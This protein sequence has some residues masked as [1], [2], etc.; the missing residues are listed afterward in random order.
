MQYC[1]VPETSPGL[2]ERKRQLTQRAI[3]RAVLTLAAERGFAQVTIEEVS[4][5]ADIAP[6]TFFNYFATKEAALLGNVPLEP[7]AA[8]A[9]RFVAGGPHGELFVDFGELMV[10]QF[11]GSLIDRELLQLRHAVF[12]ESPHLAKLHFATMRNLEERFA[13][14]IRARIAEH[15]PAVEA[16]AVLLSN[17]ASATMRSAFMSWSRADDGSSL[18]EWIRRS[19]SSVCRVVDEYR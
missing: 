14:L 7:S 8:A 2:R 16:D 1:S 17:I 11:S 10:D 5:V 9:E 12:K 18:E 13:E 19:F 6:R 4:R 3:Q 15:R